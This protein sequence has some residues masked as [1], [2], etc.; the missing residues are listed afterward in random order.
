MVSRTTGLPVDIQLGNMRLEIQRLNERLIAVEKLASRN[1]V[2]GGD[3]PKLPGTINPS[4]FPD[5]P[6]KVTC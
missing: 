2:Y 4:L 3:A 6:F 5:P 1:I